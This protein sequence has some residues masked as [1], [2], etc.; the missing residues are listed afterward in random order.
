LLKLSSINYRSGVLTL[1]N[2]ANFLSACRA[3]RQTDLVPIPIASNISAVELR[4]I[5]ALVRDN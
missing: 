1:S 2:G 4:S 5:V 3:P